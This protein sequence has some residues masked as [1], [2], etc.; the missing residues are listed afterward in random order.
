[1]EDFKKAIEEVTKSIQKMI[2]DVREK[3]DY[4]IVEE[5]EEV[6]IEIDMPGLEPSDITLSV[7][8]DGTSLKA[9]GARDDRKYQKHIRLMFKIDTSTVSA[10][11]KNGVLIITAKKI[12]EEEV[13]IP[14]RG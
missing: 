7:S 14:V 10:M 6:R 9:E 13:R 4:K 1:M 11:Y 5:G 8:K 3:K 2:E 12:K